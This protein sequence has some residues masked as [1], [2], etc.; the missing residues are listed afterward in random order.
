MV[1]TTASVKI[2]GTAVDI[3][4][5]L[6]EEQ[7]ERLVSVQEKHQDVFSKYADDL[8]FTD[9]FQHKILTTDDVPVKLPHTHWILL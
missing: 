9:T 6:T 1:S 8:G 4:E 2:H 7:K 5:I 3:G